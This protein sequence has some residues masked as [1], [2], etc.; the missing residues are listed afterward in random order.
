MST[1]KLAQTCV[2]L[3]VHLHRTDLESFMTET[4][5]VEQANKQ[6]TFQHFKE[7]LADRLFQTY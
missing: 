3:L 1:S 7:I 6:P 4:V 2:I 5:A